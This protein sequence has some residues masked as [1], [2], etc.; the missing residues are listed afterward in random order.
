MQPTYF[1]KNIN[2]SERNSTMTF[3]NFTDK[4]MPSIHKLIFGISLPRMIEEMKAY[5]HN[6]IEPVGGW[7][8]YKYFIVLRVYGFEDEPYRLPIFLTKRIFVLEF[9]R[10]R[11][12]VES[13][14]FLKHKKASNIKFKYTIEPF[15]VNSTA[16]LSVIQNIMKNMNFQL[17]KKINYD[18]KHVI[19][20]RKTNSKLGTYEH[21]ENE[22]LALIANHNYIEQDVNMSS[23]DQEE[24]KGLE[25]Q[26]MVDLI[27]C[28]IT[29]FKGERTLKR[30]AT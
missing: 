30:P 21:V 14:I 10:Q 11:L 7:F 15:V 2:L 18:P 12:H 5:M 22:V 19:S 13:E 23:N 27:T 24:E 6:S 20:Q 4:V 28:I 3:I 26:T 25:E 9:L 1:A 16:A 8:L 29:P 17:D